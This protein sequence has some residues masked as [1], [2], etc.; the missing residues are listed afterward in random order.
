MARARA[1]ALV[2]MA[3]PAL[4]PAQPTIVPVPL[5]PG[6]TFS[7]A[8]AVTPDGRFV[9]GVANI[10]TDKIFG[11]RA[12]RWSL[13]GP[14]QQ[15]GTPTGLPWTA[16]NSISAD[17]NTI[18]GNAANRLFRWT[19]SA[20]MQ[21]LGTLPGG[22]I[23]LAYGVSA[24]GG[25][26]VGMSSDP[27]SLWAV[28]WTPA[29]GLQNLGA[30]PGGN[31]SA[32]YAVSGNAS[33]IV[34]V[35]GW[36]GPGALAVRWTVAG[37]IAQL[38]MP[39]SSGES[40]A[41]AV[42]HDASAIVGQ[43]DWPAGAR[44]ATMWQGSQIFNLG[45]PPTFTSSEARAVNADARTIVGI[46]RNGSIARAMLYTQGTGAVDLNLYLPSI[47]VN[48]T[49]WV[50]RE[51]RGVSA[52]GS[53]I[54]GTG[55][56]NGQERGFYL[57]NVPCSSLAQITSSPAD[58]TVCP[59]QDSALVSTTAAVGPTQIFWFWRAVNGP[60]GF[61]QVVDGLNSQL[62]PAFAPRFSVDPNGSRLPTLTIRNVR[63]GANLEFFMA[64]LG[65][66]NAV[67]GPIVRVTVCNGDINC[68]GVVDF[69]DLLDFLN[70]YNNL[71]PRADLNGDSVIDFNDLLE[72]INDYNTPC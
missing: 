7:R 48:L 10:Q 19:N 4:A 38:P 44:T 54:V 27:S 70:L 14:M 28:R 30:L 11:D 36:S 3:L 59:G 62:F 56:L 66:C 53:V 13:T 72:Y 40:F 16:G 23:A 61:N 68:D 24:T 41:F 64:L 22:N 47:G 65:N 2:V 18:A 17:G 55:T 58:R 21:N 1:L 46:A 12:Y 37:G 26:V 63:R 71:D 42:N 67:Q 45:M 51:A 39:G 31:N 15:L 25:L 29:S 57:Y 49:G 33:T 6:G 35:S 20:G 8:A 52:D 34:G 5:L 60:S 32:A 9:T 43:C 69:N 50:L